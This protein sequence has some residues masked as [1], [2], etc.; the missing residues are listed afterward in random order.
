MPKQGVKSKYDPKELAVVSTKQQVADLY[1]AG[2]SQSEIAEATG[3]SVPQV[4]NLL[5]EIYSEVGFEMRD[6]A[7]NIHTKNLARLEKLIAACWPWAVGKIVE[8]GTEL[9]PDLRFVSQVANLIKMQQQWVEVVIAAYQRMAAAESHDDDIKVA[10]RTFTSSNPLYD[11]A[12]DEMQNEWIGEFTELST[13][14][15]YEDREE[16][17]TGDARME[18]LEKSIEKLAKESGIDFLMEDQIDEEE[19]WTPTEE[20]D[21]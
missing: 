11:I 12:L 17:V 1:L 18:K 21:E 14:V 2:K 20:E 8:D 9:P 19:S 15:L 13:E 3:V 10:E 16:Q 7:E 4:S 5:K 6:L